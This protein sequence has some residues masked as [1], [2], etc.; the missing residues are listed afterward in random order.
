MFI[1]MKEI[2][3]LD[4]KDSATLL[5]NRIE[6]MDENFDGVLIFKLHSQNKKK[7]HNF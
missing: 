7:I 4:L 2:R 5:K 6:D 3:D 1:L